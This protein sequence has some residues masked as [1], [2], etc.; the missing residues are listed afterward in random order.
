MAFNDLQAA[1]SSFSGLSVTC[2]DQL[3]ILN[4]EV[5]GKLHEIL[6]VNETESIDLSLVGT[7]RFVFCLVYSYPLEEEIYFRF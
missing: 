3:K 7:K 2:V 5:I 4:D 6:I 1:V